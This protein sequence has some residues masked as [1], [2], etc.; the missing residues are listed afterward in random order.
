MRVHAVLILLCLC[1]LG[2]SAWFWYDYQ[3]ADTNKED[4]ELLVLEEASARTMTEAVL[5]EEQSYIISEGDTA[6]IIL[7]KLAINEDEHADILAAAAEVYDLSFIRLGREIRYAIEDGRLLF[8]AYDI[9]REEMLR[10]DRDRDRFTAVV[11]EIQYETEERF[12]SATIDS[13]LF[14]AGLDAGLSEAF[15]IT[16]AEIFGWNIDFA[17]EVQQGDS[18]RVFYEQRYREG[19]D[20]G[21][22]RIFAAEFFVGGREYSGYLFRNADG[23][24]HYYDQEGNSLIRQFLKA[25]LRYSRI[26]SGYSYARFHPVIGRTTEHRAID[27]AAP[28]G[29]PIYATADGVVSMAQWYGGFGNYIDIRH[30]DIYATQYA[31]LSRYASG[32]R[33]GVRVTQGQLIGY[34]GSTG[35]SSG[36]HLH[37]QIKK[38]GTLVNPL[39]IELPAG[40]PVA[41]GDKAAFDRVRDEFQGRLDDVSV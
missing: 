35:W 31:H 6:G 18:F 26:T 7:E 25:P 30:N 20:A 27:Y 34:V 28:I 37:Y 10:I 21:A 1:F 8:L 39:Q 22:G 32:I 33:P 23:D 3:F 17:T 41:A 24:A 36:P 38:H 13:S 12:A 19:E 29:T 4:K 9:D 16:L 40:D 5:F 11:E 15:I 14:L 2:G